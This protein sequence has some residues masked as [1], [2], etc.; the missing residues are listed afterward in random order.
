MG[1]MVDRREWFF[2]QNIFFEHLLKMGAV[3]NDAW[4][5]TGRFADEMDG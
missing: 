2:E 1:H 5:R 3:L 4:H